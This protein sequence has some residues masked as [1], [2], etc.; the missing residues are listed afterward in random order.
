MARRALIGHTGFVGSTLRVAGGYTDFYNSSNYTTMA[1]ET[2]DEIVCSGIS[3]VKWLA[4]K[5][6]EQDWVGI[7]RL[8]DVLA[9]TNAKRFVLISTIDVYPDPNQPL[10]EDAKIDGLPNHAYGR[11]R[12][13]VEKWVQERFS[14]HLIARLPAVFG[15]GL[16]KNALYDLL[17][18]NGVDKINPAGQ[19]QWYPVARLSDDIALAS[20]A[21]LKLVNLFTEPLLMGDI[22][23]RLFPSSPVGPVTHPA[24]S[25]N[26][27]TQYSSLFG[28]QGGFIMGGDQVMTA[29]RDYVASMLHERATAT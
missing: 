20:G 21:G 27:R 18:N 17:N 4:N 29:L 23:D 12:L 10:T 26:L 1:G 24:P 15:P 19:F 3:A 28:G 25:Y 6:P 2:F 13:A 16:R 11:H 22:I 14:E 9:T 5:E 7:Q 8:L